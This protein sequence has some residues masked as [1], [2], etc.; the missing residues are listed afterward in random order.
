MASCAAESPSSVLR[1]LRFVSLSLLGL[2][3]ATSSAGRAQLAA[4]TPPSA[5]A[6]RIH[7]LRFDM[8]AVDARENLE[9]GFWPSMQQSLAIAKDSYYLVH[10]KAYPGLRHLEVLQGV[11]QHGGNVTLGSICAPNTQRDAEP[12]FGYR[13]TVQALFERVHRT[14]AV[15]A[16]AT[17]PARALSAGT[18][19]VRTAPPARGWARSAAPPGLRGTR[20][21]R[22]ISPPRG[23]KPP[24]ER[25][26]LRSSNERRS[27]ALCDRALHAAI[28]TDHELQHHFRGAASAFR[29]SDAR[30]GDRVRRHECRRS[31][32]ARGGLAPDRRCQQRHRGYYSEPTTPTLHW[33]ERD[34]HTMLEST[35]TPMRKTQKRW[36]RLVCGGGPH[37]ERPLALW[38]LLLARCQPDYP[39]APTACDD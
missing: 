18:A 23:L 7:R 32:L 39:L 10:S 9:L 38:L 2:S 29:V 22:L 31:G 33:T 3:L 13:P 30:I 12:S 34:P 27:A 8:P 35:S 14:S 25:R 37:P 21:D 6:P 11:S 28:A 20:R 1:H 15:R 5:Y 19:S 16:R 36:L 4:P 17:D 24:I 26:L